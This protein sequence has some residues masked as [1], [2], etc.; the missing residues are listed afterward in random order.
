MTGVWLWTKG[1]DLKVRQV[2]EKIFSLRPMTRFAMTFSRKL[3][4]SRIRYWVT[5]F[6][7]TQKTKPRQLI[8]KNSA[9]LR[10]SVYFSLFSCVQKSKM[11]GLRVNRRCPSH[12]QLLPYG[13]SVCSSRQPHSI[14]SKTNGKISWQ[15]HCHPRT[16]WRTLQTLVLIRFLHMQNGRWKVLFIILKSIQLLKQ[17]TFQVS[18]LRIIRRPT[19]LPFDPFML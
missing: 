1:D 8:L 19:R 3:V 5:S 10:V 9:K 15:Y 12:V 6:S 7:Q 17:S 2:F 11:S 13:K 14:S 18:L 4:T 16:S